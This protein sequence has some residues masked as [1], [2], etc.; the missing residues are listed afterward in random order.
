MGW[1]GTLVPLSAPRTLAA[2]AQMP[3]I[4]LPYVETH[5]LQAGCADIATSSC[6]GANPA[7]LVKR[8]KLRYPDPHGGV[9][10]S[11]ADAAAMKNP[12][13]SIP[14]N[15]EEQ[16]F[17]VWERTDLSQ[18]LSSSPAL[19]LSHAG[20]AHDGASQEREKRRLE[21]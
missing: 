12:S 5:E 7:V 8:C 19:L 14:S 6:S 2:M 20:T 15:G 1:T 17:H 9:V 11:R 21:N 18:A 16:I 4:S 10:P 13:A 3:K